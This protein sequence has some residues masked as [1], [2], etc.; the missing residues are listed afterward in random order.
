MLMSTLMVL[1]VNFFVVCM[2]DPLHFLWSIISVCLHRKP[3][4]PI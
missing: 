3:F 1:F 4:P 2:I